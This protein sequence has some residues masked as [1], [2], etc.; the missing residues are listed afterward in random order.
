[1]CIN[2]PSFRC[3]L[4]RF[5]EYALT[6]E[7]NAACLSK[8]AVIVS[9]SI[10]VVLAFHHSSNNNISTLEGASR[11]LGKLFVM[12]FEMVTFPC[13]EIIKFAMDTKRIDLLN[14]LI[15]I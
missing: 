15:F 7:P 1:M 5:Y 6:N 8:T 14:P 10:V 9:S 11:N 13:R 3:D 12:G 2:R 4:Q